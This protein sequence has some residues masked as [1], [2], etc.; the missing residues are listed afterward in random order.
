MVLRFFFSVAK[1]LL[2]MSLPKDLLH[3]NVMVLFCWLIMDDEWVKASAEHSKGD[4]VRLDGFDWKSRVKP[5]MTMNNG[6]NKY[7]IKYYFRWLTVWDFMKVVH[8]LLN[9]LCKNVDL[10]V[11][12]D[13][14]FRSLCFFKQNLYKINCRLSST[15]I[16]CSELHIKITSQLCHKQESD[17]NWYD[18]ITIISKLIT[19]NERKK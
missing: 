3:K 12:E 10:T 7:V 5:I 19:N 18:N 13:H 4:Q 9:S 11:S 2:F 17:F 8:V 6:H 15:T 1:I 16:W 14:R